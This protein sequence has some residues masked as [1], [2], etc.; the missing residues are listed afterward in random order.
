MLFSPMVFMR[1]VSSPVCA[2]TER[3]PTAAMNMATASFEK[4]IARR[5]YTKKQ[6]Y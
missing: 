3:I 6:E 1:S 5:R 4:S 2:M